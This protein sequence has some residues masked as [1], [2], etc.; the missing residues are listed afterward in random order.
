MLEADMNKLFESN[1]QLNPIANPDTKITFHNA[2]VIQYEQIPLND[3]FGQNLEIIMALEK[4][5]RMG[6]Q[7]TPLQKSYEM[8]IG[9]QSFTAD[10]RAANRKFDCSKCH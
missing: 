3:R 1:R 9:T 2:P 5:L 10:F 8:M 6:I 7:K 4:L